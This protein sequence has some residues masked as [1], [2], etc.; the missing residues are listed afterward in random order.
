LIRHGSR[1]LHV[2]SSAALEFIHQS[3]AWS[4]KLQE[5]YP[6]SMPK[7]YPFWASDNPLCKNINLTT[8]AETLHGWQF[9]SQK[10]CT[11]ECPYQQ[12]ACSHLA[13]QNLC[14]SC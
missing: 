11:R 7:P 10:V 4:V 3:W 13:P 12:A 5:P 2:S 6:R 9:Q 1:N 8:V 14:N